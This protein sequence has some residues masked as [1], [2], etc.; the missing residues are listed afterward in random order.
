MDSE[1]HIQIAPSVLAA[2]FARL[3]RQV[4]DA[5]DAGADLIHVDI[6]DGQ[7]VPN[8]SFGQVVVDAVRQSTHLPLNIHLM[9]QEPDRLLPGFM[10][11]DSDQVIVHAEA[12]T[13]LHRTVSYVKEEGRQIG[14]AINPGTPLSAVAEVLQFLDIVLVMSV[15][16]G[17][18]GQIFIPAA[19]SKMR[20]LRRI[21]EDKGY[22]ARIEV[23]GGIKADHTAQDSVRA[24]S[25]ILVAGTA[26]FNGH[27]SV[28]QAMDRMRASIQG[29]SAEV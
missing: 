28:A 26:I 4:A 18:G 21:I 8:I 20:R 16:P 22:A 14:V 17:F 25:T 19:L 12:C 27:E 3:G 1:P 2:D 10:K 6:M 9:I 29:L 5:T 24:G 11:A 7:F 23:D 13:H 15:D